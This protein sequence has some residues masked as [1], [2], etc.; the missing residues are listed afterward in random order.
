M[1]LVYFELA[2]T[3]NSYYHQW[4]IGLAVSST[5]RIFADYT[6]GNYTYT[7]GEIVNKT[8][9]KPYPSLEVQVEPSALTNS[10]L[11]VNFGT[12]NST[13]LISVQAL[14][15][16]AKTDTRDETL[17]VVDTGRPSLPDGSQAYGMPGG[18]KIIA[19]SL[20]NDTV[21]ATY[22]FPEKVHYVGGSH[23]LEIF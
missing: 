4:P 8:A 2:L 5:G 17:W 22:T 12:S 19:I 10:S 18:P 9:E 20:S 3:R 6:R 11:G 23:V 14:I 15:I 1:S 16:T 21:Y 13:G 7:V